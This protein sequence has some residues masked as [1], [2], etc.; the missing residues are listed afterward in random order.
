MHPRVKNETSTIRFC[1]DQV[2]VH[3]VDAKMNLN[4][5]LSGLKPI[6]GLKPEPEQRKRPIG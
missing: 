1:A 2:W 4:L 6:S 3:P 5:H